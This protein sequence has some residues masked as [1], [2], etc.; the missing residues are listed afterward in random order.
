MKKLIFLSMAIG[1]LTTTYSRAQVGIGTN[2]PDKSAVLDI[3]STQRGLLIPRIALTATTSTSPITGTP[4][5]SLMVYNTAT[6]GDVVPGFYY[7]DSTQTKWVLIL[8]DN[9]IPTTATTSSVSGLGTI[10]VT[11]TT[12]GSNT[13]YAVA[14]GPGL[15]G[16]VLATQLNS[17]TNQLEAVWVDPNMFISNLGSADNGLTQT[18]DTNGNPLIELGGTLT[19]N[20]NL[21]AAGF[22]FSLSNLGQV[23]SADSIVVKEGNVLRVMSPANLMDILAR[24]GVSIS[25]DSV[26]LGGTLD[27]V[28]TIATD[29]INTLNI[30]GLQAANAA[31]KIIVTEDG[32]GELATVKRVVSGSIPTTGL[33]VNATNLSNYSPYV[34]QVYLKIDVAD[35]SGTDVNLTLPDPIAAIGQVFNVKIVD[36][37]AIGDA[38]NYLNILKF[39]TTTPSP[40][41]TL[42]Y[43]A[44]P[45]QAWV[46]KSNGTNWQIVSSK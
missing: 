32:T 38:S 42:S 14:I 15:D 19:H 39:G 25:N 34:R 28:T 22:D 16:Q 17:T 29:A 2:Q 44:V 8:T 24:N 1:L 40:S 36:P 5:N 7:W 3:V 31:N 37:T 9:N 10:I 43:G 45:Y 13:D 26:V 46:I 23:T 20:T 21:D 18:I 12:T 41:N 33:E 4:A 27:R 6:V 30:S 35:L 11:S